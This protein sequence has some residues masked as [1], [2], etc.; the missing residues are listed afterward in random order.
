MTT[1]Y[2]QTKA[3][4][5]DVGQVVLV[6]DTAAHTVAGVAKRYNWKGDTKRIHLLFSTVNR[7]YEKRYRPN[8]RL[9]VQ[10]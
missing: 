4:Y 8:A 7:V 10:D 5:V 1:T 6:S 9:W 3:E 2:R